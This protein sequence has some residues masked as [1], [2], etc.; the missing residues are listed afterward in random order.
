MQSNMKDKHMTKYWSDSLN[1][2]W[3]HQAVITVFRSTWMTSKIKWS[4]HRPFLYRCDRSP[5]ARV[6]KLGIEIPN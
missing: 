2:Q 1:P 6:S 5:E 3:S 4:R